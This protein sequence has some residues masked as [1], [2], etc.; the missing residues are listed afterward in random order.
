MTAAGEHADRIGLA[1]DAGRRVGFGVSA[2]ALGLV[3]F[4]SLL[5]AEKAILAVVLGA[6]AIRGSKSG[7]LSRRLGRAAITLGIAFLLTVGIVLV[8]F[9]DQAV[10]FA[11]LL[12]QLS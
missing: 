9:W 7:A 5:G 1:Y 8:V 6:L 3:T 2:L 10:E 4:L 12:Q 11:R